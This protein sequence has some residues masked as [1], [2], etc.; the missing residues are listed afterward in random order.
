MVLRDRKQQ[1]IL[2]DVGVADVFA[3]GGS[4]LK[5]SDCCTSKAWLGW[6]GVLAGQECQ[7]RADLIPQRDGIAASTQC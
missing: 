3:N 6:R 4:G 2:R 5:N 1:V 7:L